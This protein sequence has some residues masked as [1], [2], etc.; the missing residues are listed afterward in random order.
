[1]DYAPVSDSGTAEIE[2]EREREREMHFVRK[3]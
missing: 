1:M 3:V 2:R